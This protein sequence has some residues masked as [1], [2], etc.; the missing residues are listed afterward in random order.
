MAPRIHRE[1]ATEIIERWQRCLLAWLRM[2]HQDPQWTPHVIQEY[3]AGIMDF[4]RL[5]TLRSYEE[6][7]NVK[8]LDTTNLA[9]HEVAQWVVDWIN[10]QGNFI[11]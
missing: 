2:H 4:T 5:S 9:L 11:I 1:V 10:H 8:I 6:V 3:A 7:A